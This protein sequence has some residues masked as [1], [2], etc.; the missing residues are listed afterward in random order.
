MCV[1]APVYVPH[2]SNHAKFP[3]FFSEMPLYLDQVES[4]FPSYILTYIC[5]LGYKIIV[6]YQESLEFS[7]S[8]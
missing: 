2:H 7:V 3:P 4:G 1:D 8:L 5:I 6:I